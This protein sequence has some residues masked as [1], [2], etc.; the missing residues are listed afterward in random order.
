MDEVPVELRAHAA[1]NAAFTLAQICF[2]ALIENGTIPQAR[3]LQLI[4]DAG[5]R[6]AEMGTPQHLMAAKTLKE[7]FDR[8][9]ERAN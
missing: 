2:W 8:L 5:R 7:I 9:C 6:Y 3:A 4:D 1:A